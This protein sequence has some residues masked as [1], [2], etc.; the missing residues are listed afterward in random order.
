M[1]LDDRVARVVLPAEEALELGLLEVRLDRGKLRLE[2]PERV[3][4]TLDA[5]LE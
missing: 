2:L 5:Q 1:D 4:F 3:A